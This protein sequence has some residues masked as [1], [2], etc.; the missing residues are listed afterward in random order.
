[1]WTLVSDIWNGVSG[2]AGY[3][4]CMTAVPSIG[5]EEGKPNLSSDCAFSVERI[6]LRGGGLNGTLQWGAGSP[7][8]CAVLTT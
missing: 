2:D 4:G 3:A 7:T 1:M 6:V 5:L 8:S